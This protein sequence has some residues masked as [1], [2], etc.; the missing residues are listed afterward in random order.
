MISA[1]QLLLVAQSRRVR[2]ASTAEGKTKAMGVAMFERFTDSA[3]RVLIL[4]T[5]A[6]RTRNCEYVGTE[7][8]LLG[9]STKMTG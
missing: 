5:G 7:H 8:I 1:A 2:E 6:A 3:R 9:W 4:A